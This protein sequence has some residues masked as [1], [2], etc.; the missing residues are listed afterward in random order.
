MSVEIKSGEVVV[1]APNRTSKRA[2][3]AFVE[4]YAGWIEKQLEKYREHQTRIEQV[5]KLSPAELDDLYKRAKAYLPERVRYYANL[6]GADFGR[7]T[8]RC[9][10]TRWGSCSAKKNLNF[11]CLLM[12]APP[13]VIDSVVAH[14][15]CH[16]K[17]MNHS[18]R[19]YDLV[20]RIYPDYRR[21]NKWLKENGRLLMA[22]IP[23]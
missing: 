22:R 17:E 4:K 2:A 1:R 14:E 7:I 20:L 8:I 18:D 23:E 6:L 3:D 5:E 11:N 16:L 13:E 12:L 21:Q 10:R 15:V 9:Q 19:F